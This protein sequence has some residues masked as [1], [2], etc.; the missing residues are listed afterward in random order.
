MIISDRQKP[1]QS[2]F[3][4]LARYLSVTGIPFC[5]CLSYPLTCPS[6]NSFLLSL[7]NN[8]QPR[9]FFSSVTVICCLHH[10]KR[11]LTGISVSCFISVWSLMYN[12]RDDK[13]ILL[14]SCLKTLPSVLSHC[15]QGKVLSSYGLRYPYFLI[16]VTSYT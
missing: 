11:F 13:L 9:P 12:H 6:T 1:L 14:L 7:L 10:S 16:T 3:R 2:N 5:L 15:L 4:A 8:L